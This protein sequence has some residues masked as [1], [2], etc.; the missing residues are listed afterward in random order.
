MRRW[1]NKSLSFWYREQW[2][3]RG[4]PEVEEE[5]YKRWP[6]PEHRRDVGK[7]DK[8]SKYRNI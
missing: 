6:G 5:A 8:L 2:G 4:E 3:I 7:L 1:E